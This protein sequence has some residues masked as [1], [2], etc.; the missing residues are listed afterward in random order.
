MDNSSMTDVRKMTPEELARQIRRSHRYHDLTCGADEYNALWAELLR[1]L[2]GQL[3]PEKLAR[4]CDKAKIPGPA[5]VPCGFPAGHH[6]Q[7]KPD[8]NHIGKA[9]LAIPRTALSAP[10]MP[11]GQ[12]REALQRLYDETVDYIRINNLGDVHHNVSMQMARDALAAPS[13]EPQPKEKE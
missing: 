7:C 12:I 2:A 3:D 4:A 11:Q 9:W 13:G 5:D 6:G 10:A 8:Y 1:R